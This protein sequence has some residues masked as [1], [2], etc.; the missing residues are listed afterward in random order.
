MQL[1]SRHL[2]SPVLKVALMVMAALFQLCCLRVTRFQCMRLHGHLRI[3]VLEVALV[4]AG[5]GVW[6]PKEPVPMTDV[7]ALAVLAL[8][9]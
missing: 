2:G 7:V 5:V 3:L 9:F 8:V 6:T 1:H 4:M